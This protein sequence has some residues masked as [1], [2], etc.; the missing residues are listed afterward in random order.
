MNNKAIA[1]IFLLLT[2]FFTFFV[3]AR[4]PDGPKADVQIKIACVGNSI[5]Y[6]S[7]IVNRQKNAYPRQLQAMLGKEYEVIN[8][9]VSGTT[10]LK[11]G[12]HPYW[13]TQEYQDAKNYDP[14]VL[15]IKLGTNDSK[16]QNRIHLDEFK[17]DYKELI[18]SFRQRNKD[19]RIVLL[20]P[21]PS[22]AEDSTQIW[23]PVIKNKIIPLTQ[24]VAFNTNSEVIGLY[25]LFVNQENLFPDK[26]HPSS[27]GATVIA[28]RL[29]EVVKLES[30]NSFNILEEAKVQQIK[31]SNFY[32][33]QQF[34][35]SLDSISC[36]IV[37][38]KNPNRNHNWVL[39][40]RFWGHEPQADIALLE[41][42]F[43]IAYCDVAN[44]FGS[45]EAVER[46]N[47]FY[48]NMTNAG[49]SKKV[50]LE[51]MSRGGLIIYNWAVEN[52]DKVACIYADA[53]VLDGL[54]WP[55][56]MVNGKGSQGD[57]KKFKEQ[58]E[59]NSQESIDNF[60]RNPIHKTKEIAQAG[61]PMF[62]VCGQA[63]QV[64]PVDE[65][66]RLFESNINNA[67][68]NIKVIYKKDTGHHPHS[69]K[70][71]TPIVDFIL[72]A[73]NNKVNFAVIPSPGS[74]YRSAAG[75][76]E[77]KGWW[78][79]KNEIDSLCRI[80]DN[81]DLILIGN[82]ITQGWGGNRTLVTYKPGLKAARKYFKD[83]QWIGA[84]ISG[85]RTEH[86]ALRIQQGDYAHIH[87]KF[88]VLTIGVNNFPYNNTEEIS[89]G[90]K[91]D[92]RLIQHHLKGSTILLFGLLPTGLKKDSYR[93]EKYDK[94]HKNIAAITH[95]ESIK[96]FNLIDL[97]SDK[98][99]NLDETYYSGDG[100][101]LNPEGYELWA[102]FIREQIDKN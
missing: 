76:K 30:D 40:A 70:N 73:T 84:G 65:N 9:G 8:F 102:K 43:H 94:I 20:L 36:K 90:I 93:R 68:G 88:V 12:D 2:S 39:R 59:L 78:Y 33:F 101:H 13:N 61:F 100:I 58:Y 41:R 85:D 23:N 29:Y 89:E 63:D 87:P 69:L 46:W 14:D 28:K 62:H 32:G 17:N 92:V 99:G 77:G 74:E 5:T 97:F 7:T 52:P 45:P 60:K 49:L 4:N 6:G 16:Q 19:I 57:W 22:F 15:F 44:L 80:S 11:N 35:F 66:T 82:S 53:P 98:N 24:K 31:E 3:S 71:P 48:L 51:G 47:K 95:D 67:G 10:L 1:Y 18:H 34:D 86:V 21:L 26:I 96:Y 91:N 37:K 56:G 50:A 79:Q 72:R 83:L 75:W 38:P 55:G 54:S 42:G 25:Q 81:I 27:L 64:V